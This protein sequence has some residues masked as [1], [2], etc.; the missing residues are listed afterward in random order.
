MVHS[1][2]FLCKII[3]NYEYADI[4]LT[5]NLYLKRYKIRDFALLSRYFINDVFVAIDKIF[6]ITSVKSSLVFP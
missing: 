1:S 2:D 3:N 6:V 5:Q 4:T